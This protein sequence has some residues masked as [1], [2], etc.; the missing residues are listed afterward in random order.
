MNDDNQLIDLALA[1]DSAAFGQLVT[2]YQ[3]RLYNTLVYVIGSAEDAR[4]VAQEAFVRAFVK[5]ET[6]QRSA[7]FYSWLYRIAL[8]MAIS[9]QRR[10]RPTSSIDQARHLA[11]EEPQDDGPPPEERLERQER[12]EQVRAALAALSEDYRVVLV[13]RDMD[14]HAYDEIAQMLE[15]PVGTV[16]S[17]LF[18]GRMQLREQL[19]EVLQE[20]RP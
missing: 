5:L 13:L 4:D 18:R 2:K 17:R 8:N 12:A 10:K 16:R 14:G 7:A 1:G 11:G 3:D 6:F 19:K 15:I 9:G 20:D